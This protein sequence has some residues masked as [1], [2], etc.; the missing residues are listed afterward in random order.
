M[1]R[2]AAVERVVIVGGGLAGARTAQALRARGFTGGVTIIGAE[3]DLPYDRPPLSKAVLLKDDP[4]DTTLPI[5]WPSLEVDLRLGVTAQRVRPGAVETTAGDVGYDG[6]VLACGALPVRLPG[7][8]SA[9]HLRRRADALALRAA[10]TPG[11]RVVVV[12]AGW[13]GAEVT[14]AA[15]A[16]GCAVTVIEAGLEPLSAALP[17][18][19]GALLRPWWAGVDLR[20]GCTVTAV[21]PD[22]VLL[23]SGERVVADVVVVAVGV[24]AADAWLAGSSGLETDRGLIVDETLSAGPGVWAVGDVAARWSTRYGLRVRGEHWDDAQHAPEVV[25]AGIVG[26]P[27]AYDPVP[28]IWSDQFGTTLQWCGVS[29]PGVWILRGD[30]GSQSWS[31]LCLDE[32]RIRA[33]L[34]VARPR[35]FVQGRRLAAA[36]VELD[37]ALVRDPAVPLKQAVA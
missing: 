30:P 10:L 3:P 24:R 4:P 5:D 27:E 1:A 33:L 32:G 2:V 8:D 16:H 13:I 11:R 26:A 31:A 29:G 25:A 36:G 23:T 21:E 19:I 35:D 6:L 17:L 18:E 12:G 15:L 22:G 9:I 14:T 7:D 20:V 37:P 28:Y 34:A